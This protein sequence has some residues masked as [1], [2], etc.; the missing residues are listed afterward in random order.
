MLWVVTFSVFLPSF[1]SSSVVWAN[2]SAAQKPSRVPPSQMFF[3]IDLPLYDVYIG[4][5]YQR[6]MR[7]ISSGGR[8]CD[9]I[10]APPRTALALDRGAGR[11]GLP[12]LRSVHLDSRS[13]PGGDRHWIADRHLPPVPLDEP[14]LRADFRALADPYGGWPLHLRARAARLLDGE[15]F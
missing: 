3:M 15:H 11:V 4:S 6:R 13:V 10:A 12:L 1:T 14:A 7:M 5:A 8:I 9:T 2:P